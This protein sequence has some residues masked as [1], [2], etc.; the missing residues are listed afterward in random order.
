M[1]ANPKPRRFRF[2]LHVMLLYVTIVGLLFGVARQTRQTWRL[3][4]RIYAIQWAPY[5]IGD[6]VKN[7]EKN[8]DAKFLQERLY[9]IQRQLYVDDDQTSAQPQYDR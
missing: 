4:D 3:Q 2:S 7:Y 1:D 8:G 6:A 9:Q 5:Q